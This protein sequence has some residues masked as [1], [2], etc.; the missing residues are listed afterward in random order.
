[1]RLGGSFSNGLVVATTAP[2]GSRNYKT[3]NHNSLYRNEVR[4]SVVVGGPVIVTNSCGIHSLVQG[5]AGLAIAP[6]NEELAEALRRLVEIG[7]CIG[8]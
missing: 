8:G 1:M 7:N 6:G 3:N 4:N 2:R 5:R